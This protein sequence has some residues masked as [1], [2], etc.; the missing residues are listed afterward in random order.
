VENGGQRNEGCEVDSTRMHGR[1]H[2]ANG[3][4]FFAGEAC[5]GLGSFAREWRREQTCLRLQGAGGG[6]DPMHEAGGAVEVDGAM[7]DGA[8]D[9]EGGAADGVMVAERAEADGRG[10][11]GP[12]AAAV[13]LLEALVREA[14]GTIGEGD[15]PAGCS[16][17]FDL[18][19]E[20]CVHG[21]L[22]SDPAQF[23]RSFCKYSECLYLAKIARIYRN[24]S[25]LLLCIR[26]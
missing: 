20:P 10:K 15:G 14:A 25:G 23:K 21:V 17:G 11:H 8:G 26:R 22:L 3:I 9:A 2:V 24:L 7:S 16:V 4:T 13:A 1:F 12:L 6:M 18:V 5:A 19:A